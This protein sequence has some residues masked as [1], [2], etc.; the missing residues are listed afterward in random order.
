MID[1][2]IPVYNEGKNI[3]K[4]FDGISKN[5]NS[6]CRLLIVYDSEEDNT[7]PIVKTIKNS[8]NFNIK[9]V[10]NIY[11][12]GALNAIKTGLKSSTH[13]AILVMMADLCDD[14]RI[15]DKMYRKIKGGGIIL[16]VGL[17]I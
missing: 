3:K 2:I 13:Q 1:I 10:K 16:Y 12:K 4:L 7:L 5:I 17:G 15:V 11:G 6:K 14:L 9:L 8:Y